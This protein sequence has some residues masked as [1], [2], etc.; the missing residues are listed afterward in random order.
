MMEP[1]ETKN[2]YGK[3][4]G[5]STSNSRGTEVSTYRC[6]L[7]YSG[8]VLDTVIRSCICYNMLCSICSLLVWRR[9]SI[10]EGA[11]QMAID[12]VPPGIMWTVTKVQ[13][14]A[15]LSI[16]EASKGMKL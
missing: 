13:G 3:S 14:P 11:F 7:L 1:Q 12:E 15:M 9:Y 16:L 2:S 5:Y 8:F 10:T 4:C 6:S